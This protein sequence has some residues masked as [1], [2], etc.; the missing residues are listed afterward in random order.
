MDKISQVVAGLNMNSVASLVQEG[1]YTFALNGCI[2][3][4]D[5]N[6]YSLQNEQGTLLCVTL[7]DLRVVGRL[8]IL[9][10]NL[11]VFWLTDNV[12]SEIGVVN[13]D[14]CTY[15]T[16]INSPC[17]GLSTEAPIHQAV[18]KVS[19][20]S[21]EIFWT[22]GGKRKW[23]DLE[24]LPFLEIPNPDGCE[25]IIT[26][27]IDCNKLLVQPNFNIPQLQIES[28]DSDGE[29]EAG[30]VQFG[31]QYSNVSSEAY[32]SIYSITNPLSIFD[33]N[34]I[35]QDFNYKVN[36][37]VN[38]L[39][40]NIDTS[41]F[42]DYYNLIVIKT[43][44][45][46]ATP[47]IVGTYKI[48]KET[49]LIS[50]T[51][52]NKTEVSLTMFDV[53]E[54]F[55]IYDNVDGVTTAQDTII[56]KS[57]TTTERINYQKIWN[58]VNLKWQTHR[59]RADK[60][61]ADELNIV[62]KKGFFRDEIYTFEGVFLLKNGLQTDRFLISSRISAPYDTELIFNSDV[63]QDSTDKCEVAEASPRWQL[64]NTASVID[65]EQQLI[66][67]VCGA[68][69][70]YSK[71][72]PIEQSICGQK[73][74][75]EDECYEGPY[76]YGDFA[77]WESTEKYP[78]NTEIWG[79]LADKP[80]R[81]HKFPDSIVT[82]I[83]DKNFIYPLGVKLDAQE[84]LQIIQDS[85]LS[86]EQKDN[87][88][89]FKIV[90]GNRAN[91]KSVV[92]RGLLNNV[93]KYSREG[94]EYFYPNYPF[95]DLRVDPFI[96]SEN[97]TAES[98]DDTVQNSSCL[99]YKIRNT[100]NAALVYKYIKCDGEETSVSVP[101]NGNIT[102]CA[103]S[104]NIED[105]KFGNDT[106][107]VYSSSNK[108]CQ[109]EEEEESS[110]I[111]G[112]SNLNGFTNKERY[113][114]HS[115]DTHFFQ[116]SLG[117]ILKLETAE[118]GNS[119]GHF[120]QVKNHAKYRFLSNK[121]VLTTLLFSTGIGFASG[122]Y[123][124]SNNVFNG[125]AAYTAF[126][127]VSE[128]I[129][130][131]LPKKNPAYQFNSLGFYDNYIPVKNEGNKQ[132]RLEL[133]SY[134]SPG[135]LS[136]GDDH[137]LNNFQRESSVYL[138]TTSP[139]PFVSEI[140]G[141]PEDNS[142]YTLSQENLCKNRSNVLNKD[143][144]SYYGTIKKNFQ[145]QYGAV[146][147]YNSVDTGAQ[148]LFED[149]T[150]YNK[151]K[152]IFGGDCF[153]NRFA[154]KNKLPF[155][156]DNRVDTLDEADVFYNEIGNI[157]FPKYW[158]STDI[159]RGSLFGLFGIKS[160]NFDCKE[161]K[162]F[163]DS[164]VIYLFSYGIPYFWC[165]SEVNVDLRQPYNGKEGDF[166]PHV[167]TDIPDEWLQEINTS[168]QNDNTYFY[169]KTFSK[170]NVENV[171]NSLP[172]DFTQ[173][174]CKSSFPFRAI[175]SEKQKSEAVEKKN[176]WLVYRPTSK[177]DFPQNN[178]NLV[179]LDGIENRQVLAR[180]E[181]KTFLY[182]ALLTIPTST[183]Q[184]YLGQSLFDQN[185]P[186]LDYSDTDL[187]YFG[188]QHKMFLK[189]EYGDVS[190]DAERGSVFLMN[191]QK[192]NDISGDI[193]KFLIEYLPF[194]IRK[195]FP[196]FPI[197]NHFNGCGLHGVYDNKYKRIIITKKDYIPIKDVLFDGTRFY[198]EK[199][200]TYYATSGSCCPEGYSKLNG[201]CEK[202]IKTA[203]IQDTSTEFVATPVSYI[204]Y[205]ADG[206][207]IYS[208]INPDGSGTF[209]TIPD[210]PF[211]TNLDGV[212]G[213]L[214]RVGFWNNTIDFSPFD[215][216]VYVTFEVNVTDEKTY[217]VG[218]AGDNYFGLEVDCEEIFTSTGVINF[219]T[220]N[221]IPVTLSAGRHVFKMKVM[222][223]FQVGLN[224][225][226]FGAEIYDNTEAEIL[227][228]TGYDDLNVVFSTADLMGETINNFNY[229]CPDGECN[230]VV[231]EGD[232]YYC[233]SNLIEEAHCEN[234]ISVPKVKKVKEYIDVS[235]TEY[236]ANNSFTLSY[237]FKTQSWVSFHSYTPSYYVG[238]A[239]FFYSS[240]DNLLW[241]H[242]TVVNLFNNYYGTKKPYII[243]YPLYFKGTDEIIQNV[244]DY[245]KILK[246]TDYQDF[247][248]T[249]DVYFS[250]A[251]LYN[252]QQCSGT[253][254]L[255]KKP[256]NSISSYNKYPIYHPEEKEILY[257]KS[258][259][260]YQFNTFW[261]LQKSSQQPM[262]KKPIDSIL[263]ELN[264][265]NMNYS[266]RSFNKAPMMSKNSL[267]RLINE[268][269]DDCKFISQ[270][271][272][273]GTQ[274]SFK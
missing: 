144:S 116:P 31:I 208:S 40:T 5:G 121:A 149:I 224:P 61:Y 37:S 216:Y 161:G 270:F 257:T 119:R 59:I 237:S 103:E 111:P 249:D 53:F 101:G 56:W 263:K 12:N 107:L 148:Y 54:K 258:N 203:A 42:Y 7:P 186:P 232:N 233:I 272:I 100:A 155:F 205:S 204:T 193:S 87:I 214:N 215:V 17:I 81:H 145:N 57:V 117:N 229:S 251:I 14:T 274:T 175:F 67:T 250:H 11:I 264:N 118:W 169:N 222:N 18:Y 112:I 33:P 134:A 200:K 114:F 88:V 129:Y 247:I 243:E 235:N 50:Y 122:T 176:N 225:A 199:D 128:L 85:D 62:E 228:S 24:N 27:Q 97:N 3:N 217:Y 76:Q 75:E 147:S 140:A 183:A 120:V 248:E 113:T 271:L 177:F 212:S 255:T 139:L 192:V 28:V 36:K 106:H 93:G 79:E 23:M 47:Y 1:Q 221:I 165:E 22:D 218:I 132:R 245:S 201:Q 157:G 213:P 94:T 267:I 86:Q 84:L 191:G 198:T 10:K 13:T 197:D 170:Q 178:G 51:G 66:E 174:K 273:V 2:E 19:N 164:G 131:L 96:L 269:V 20:C 138:K 64:Y 73:Q 266:K 189:T 268:D 265:D 55:P 115:P 179:S 151:D 143:I 187:G 104:S 260:F 130:K 133:A 219:F 8:N 194:Q 21:T 211:W 77:Y 159:K 142:R 136:V 6:S 167:S 71:N 89:G 41:G 46:I 236:F 195:Y 83:H 241:K 261:A 259:S 226:A 124:L 146:Y 262:W 244:K 150:P 69:S 181:N 80:I 171:F 52:Q 153:I 127:V 239:N 35:T 254:K 43:I 65:F 109:S 74:Y 246:Y 154:L 32:T 91:N 207:N 220:W 102:I 45:N 16:K 242:N 26:D 202:S 141:V 39:I 190:I 188:S 182:N 95:N 38:V 173:D 72:G 60:P 108:F 166:F 223:T 180:F 240:E 135:V 98:T 156:I 152:Y 78:C 48:T 253:L 123:G 82:H 15:T 4:F 44:N 238:N 105:N 9:E 126:M 209:I 125:T 231:K 92:A 137:S 234:I 70:V 34:K 160:N 162:F 163:Y 110:T 168:I 210:N 184:A 63:P 172:L 230:S 256:K 68:R 58:K 25:N 29:L 227:A 90:R 30:T 99:E 196:Q 252:N 206:T 158:F 49:E 185:T